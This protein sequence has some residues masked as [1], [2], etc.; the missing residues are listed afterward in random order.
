MTRVPEKKI[1]NQATKRTLNLSCLAAAACLTVWATD[2]NVFVIWSNQQLK[3]FRKTEMLADYGNH[4]ARM[5]HRDKDGEVEIHADWTD[6]FVIETGSATLLI[7]GT[8]V[9][10]HSTGPGETRA[11]SVTGGDKHPVVPGDIVHIPAG[12]PHQFLVEKGKTVDYFA[13]KVPAK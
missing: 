4:N 11:E 3:A 1:M 6:V 13:L 10:P 2:P 5:T 8:P 12:I 7:G 9:K